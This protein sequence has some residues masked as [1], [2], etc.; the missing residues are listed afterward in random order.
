MAK[1]WLIVETIICIV[2]SNPSGEAIAG[3]LTLQEIA[4]RGFWQ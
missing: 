3:I 1:I 2:F 4:W